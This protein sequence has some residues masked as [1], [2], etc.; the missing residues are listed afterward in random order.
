LT[1]VAAALAGYA[2]AEGAARIA[3]RRRARRVAVGRRTVIEGSALRDRSAPAVAPAAAAT[4]SVE[5]TARPAAPV[6]APL[7]TPVA[8][9]PLA[10]PARPAAPAPAPLPSRAFAPLAPSPA[11]PAALDSPEPLAQTVATRSR[12]RLVQLA[13]WLPAIVGVA[14]AAALGV[15]MIGGGHILVM[16]TPSMGT[17]AP[18]GSLVLTHELGS[19]RLHRGMLIAFRVPETNEIYM[20]RIARIGPGGGIRTR[21]DLNSGD[22]GWVLTRTAIVGVPALIVPGLGWLLLAAPW[23]LGVLAFGVVLAH[24]LPRSWRPLARSISIAGA[25]ALPLY[26]LRPFMRVTVIAA[27]HSHQAFFA[28]LVNGGL[29]P[30]RVTLASTSVVIAPAHAGT[31]SARIAGQAAAQL[32]AHAAIPAWGWLLIAAF[33]LLPLLAGALAPLGQPTDQLAGRPRRRASLGGLNA[34]PT[35]PITESGPR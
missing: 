3:R 21:G 16:Q 13:C 17:T 2:A 24:F 15:W 10:L 12:A 31:I 1:Y 14:L 34:S 22:D 25:I 7:P 32:S 6:S 20:H 4:V 27:G 26:I 23:A 5:L 28:R 30:L 33:V 18:T 11:P 29:F 8:T 35:R 19:E 9:V